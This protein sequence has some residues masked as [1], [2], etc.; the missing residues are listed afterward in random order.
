MGELLQDVNESELLKLSARNGSC[1]LCGAVAHL[2]ISRL[3]DTRFGIPGS[4][5]VTRCSRC[6][7]EQIDTPPSHEELKHL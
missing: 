5:N 7:L 1:L 3:M 4:Y 6:G 2:T